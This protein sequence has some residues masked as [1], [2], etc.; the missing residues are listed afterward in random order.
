MNLKN[1]VLKRAAMSE[2]DDRVVFTAST[3]TVDRYGDVI[4]QGGWDL[5]AYQRNPVV[6]LNHN[7][8]SLPIG[9]GHVEVVDGSLQVGIEFDRND[10]QAVRIERKAREGYIH[11]VSVGFNPIEFSP[12]SELPTDHAHYTEKGG[13]LFSRSELLEVSVVTIPANSEATARSADVGRETIAQ[14]R[15]LI[16]RVE[17][18]IGIVREEIRHILAV[19]REEDGSYRVLFAG[20]DQ[21]VDAQ[22]P[23]GYGDEDNDEDSDEDMNKEFLTDDERELLSVITKYRSSNA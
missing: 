18:D 16:A 20:G 3:D 6:L 5:A 10:Y 2:G 9:R 1:F 22:E 13:N 12:R 4:D 8:T 17:S 14:L 15:M 23:R 7:A 21:D 19:D 11:A